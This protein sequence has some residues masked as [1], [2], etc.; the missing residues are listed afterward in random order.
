MITA[1]KAPLTEADLSILFQ[2]PLFRGLTAGE[3][4]LAM[5]KAVAYTVRFSANDVIVEA[6]ASFSAI[7]ILVEGT[8]AVI[9]SGERRRVIH[10]TLVVGDIFGVSSLFD[11]QSPFPTTVK[12]IGDC[13]VIL[14]SEDDVGALLEANASIAK[15]YIALLTKKIRFLNHRLDSLAGRS[16]EERVAE[17]LLSSI[18]AGGT[19]GITKSALASM[20]GLGRASLYR[21]LDLFESNGF[22]RTSRDRIEILNGNA[23]KTFIK[24]RKES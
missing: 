6:G 14:L 12:A 1:T 13:R 4:T 18:G 10:K 22:I 2:T 15:N 8:A 5:Q 9:R 11:E 21:I 3:C 24:S 20:L 23:L 19:L 16:A 17:H 7:G